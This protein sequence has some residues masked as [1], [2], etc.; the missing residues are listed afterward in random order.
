MTSYE[1]YLRFMSLKALKCTNTQKVDKNRFM[2]KYEVIL[3]MF[4]SN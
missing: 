3:A 2:S 1:L 4:Q